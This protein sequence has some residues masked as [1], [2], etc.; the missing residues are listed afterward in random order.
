MGGNVAPT[1]CGMLIDLV[2]DN[3]APIG[4]V[5]GTSLVAPNCQ[6]LLESLV[7][8]FHT[9]LSGRLPSLTFHHMNM[10]EFPVDEVNTITKKVK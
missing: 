2:L 9:A 3:V 4:P 6:S 10:W 1:S 5:L 8:H 7:G